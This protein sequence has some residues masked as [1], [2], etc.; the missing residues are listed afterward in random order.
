MKK[1]IVKTTDKKV[2]EF[3]RKES[4]EVAT[5]INAILIQTKEDEEKIVK[6]GLARK[7]VCI[8]CTDWKIIPLENLIAKLKGKAEIIV[9]VHSAAEAKLALE[10]ME[11]GADGVVIETND[12]KELQ[13]TLE[14][15]RKAS[16]TETILLEPATVISIKDVG[17][18]ARSC[19]DTVTL[20]KE[21]EGMLVG[22][23]SSGMFLIQAEVAKNELA[24]PRPFRVNAGAISMYVLGAENK[25]KYLEEVEAG[26]QVTITD[27]NGKLRSAAVG[28]SKIEMRPLVLVE[29]KTKTGKIA[30]VILQNA[31]T[32]RLVT[33]S[34]SIPVTELKKGE[35]VL[36][37]VE[38][39]G[40]HFGT[41][42]K[43]ET[44]LEK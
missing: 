21:G 37:H 30:K 26:T 31:E 11:L 24:S 39:G 14:H 25:T 27:R 16:S 36:V 9:L 43:D 18:G 35:G 44:I 19:V 20:M 6:E 28:R 22:S 34:G 13:K 15:V 17:I 3:A 23:S 41:L 32:I 1:I 2:E 8:S 4:L 5:T 40:R 42:L 33:L 12:I 29:A 10:T 7:K 38:E